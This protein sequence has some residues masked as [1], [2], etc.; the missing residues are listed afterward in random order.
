MD[1][2]L[3]F[4]RM[5]Y[6]RL[7]I[8]GTQFMAMPQNYKKISGE[9][10]RGYS[11][12]KF[13]NGKPTVFVQTSGGEKKA[14]DLI[15][16]SSLNLTLYHKDLIEKFK[17]SGFTGWESYPIKILCKNGEISEDYHAFIIKGICGYYD[18]KKSK[19]IDYTEDNGGYI[20]KEKRYQGMYFDPESWDGSDIVTMEKTWMTIISEPVMQELKR[21]KAKVNMT[22][23]SE[24]L[25]LDKVE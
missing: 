24:H 13:P 17:E 11:E 19:I 18:V 14:P 7:K 2:S 20:L 16:P 10:L 4:N 25:L 15:I 5:Y 1:S 8:S 23:L 9:E 21:Q 3:N 22:R 6:L 12:G